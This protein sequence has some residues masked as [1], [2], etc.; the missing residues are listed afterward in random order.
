MIGTNYTTP[1]FRAYVFVHKNDLRATREILK[2]TKSIISGPKTIGELT[3]FHCRKEHT[4]VIGENLANARIK[5]N[6]FELPEAAPQLAQTRTNF[7]LG[8]TGQG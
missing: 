3:M 2:K 6:A 7:M 5:A 8:K 4:D 1:A